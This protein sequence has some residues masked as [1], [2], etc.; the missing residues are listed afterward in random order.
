MESGMKIALYIKDG[1]EQIVLTP[2]TE[3]ETAILGK[4]HD[5]AG[6]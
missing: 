3:T 1:L 4:L 5:Q 6:R 2:E